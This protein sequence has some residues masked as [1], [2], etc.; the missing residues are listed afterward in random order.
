MRWGL[1]GDIRAHREAEEADEAPAHD[2]GEAQ[3]DAHVL[4]RALHRQPAHR[5]G[6]GRGRRQARVRVRR[7]SRTRVVRRVGCA[8]MWCALRVGVR[9][10]RVRVVCAARWC[11]QGARACCVRCAC[12]VCAGRA[13]CALGV[14][15]WC[16]LYMVLV[17]CVVRGGRWV[18]VWGTHEKSAGLSRVAAEKSERW[19]W[20]HDVPHAT[21]VALSEDWET[22]AAEPTREEI[23]GEAA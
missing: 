3:L 17:V 10:A 2:H 8:C 1:R 4:G 12:V 20:S 21:S 5:V 16:A 23:K 14:R 15:A 22:L 19:R 13:W 11:A 18:C 9:R 6:H 7:G